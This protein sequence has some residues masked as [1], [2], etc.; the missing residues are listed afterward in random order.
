MSRKKGDHLIDLKKIK[1]ITL[2]ITDG[3]DVVQELKDGVAELIDLNIMHNGMSLN[4]GGLESEFYIKF[5]IWTKTISNL[6]L[7]IKL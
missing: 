4:G 6:L 5:I 3:E 2:S 7:E 1:S